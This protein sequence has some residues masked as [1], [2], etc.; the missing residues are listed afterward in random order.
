[1]TPLA[2]L[3]HTVA[4]AAA[5]TRQYKDTLPPWFRF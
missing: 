1:M 5:D 4:P 2:I 3:H